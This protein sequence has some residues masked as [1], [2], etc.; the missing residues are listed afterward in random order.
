MR[1]HGRG[2]T[3]GVATILASQPSGEYSQPPGAEICIC[4]VP[5][6]ISSAVSAS[7]MEQAKLA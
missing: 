2:F 1:F 6:Q 4:V 5:F 7:R 3:L